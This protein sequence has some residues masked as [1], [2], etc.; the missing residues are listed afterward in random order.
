MEC[1]LQWDVTK[2]TTKGK[3]IL[4]TVVAFSAA[5][6]EQGRKTLHRHWQ[7][8]VKEINQTVQNCLFHED[9]TIRDRARKT[10]CK[11]IDSVITASYGE[12]LCI[13]H[14]CLSENNDVF[15]KQE[16]VQNI[17]QEQDPCSFQRAGHKELCTEIRGGLMSCSDCGKNISTSDIINSCLQL[18]RGTVIPSNRLKDNRPD[19]IIPLSKERLDMAAYTFTHHMENG[20]AL[21]KDCFWGNKNVWELLLK[22]RF[23]KHSACH[24]ASYF[25]KG[26]ECRFL[27][28]FTSTTSTYIHEDKG[29]QNKNEILWHSLDGSTREICPFI[30]LPKRPMGCQYINPHNSLILNV[31]NFNTNIQIGDVSQVFYSTLYTSKSTQEEDSEKQL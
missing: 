9:I 10:F 23:E 6:E 30:V 3:G 25:K 8:W 19:T 7:I 31:F 18:W 26:C 12:D 16:M 1:M 11:Q 24:K 27:F 15:H 4:G 28:P 13:T 17:F 14:N 29:V 2:K 22:Y 20:C 21:E 5:D